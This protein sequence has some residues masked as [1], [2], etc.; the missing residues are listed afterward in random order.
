MKADGVALVTLILSLLLSQQQLTTMCEAA[1]LPVTVDPS[2]VIT[3]MKTDG[4]GTTACPPGVAQAWVNVPPANT[5]VQGS[6]TLTL[7]FT[8]RRVDARFQGTVSDGFMLMCREGALVCSPLSVTSPFVTKYLRTTSSLLTLNATIPAAITVSAV[9]GIPYAE[10]VTFMAWAVATTCF[11]KQLCSCATC[12]QRAS[13][14]Q[15]PW[16][17]SA[18]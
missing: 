18:Q 13:A 2:A 9:V 4:S 11:I 17:P 12:F 1:P 7:S 10:R 6:T 16:R 14:T 8:V 3:C 5:F 15:R